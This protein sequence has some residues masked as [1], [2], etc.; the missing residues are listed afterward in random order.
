MP[1]RNRIIDITGM[2]FGRWT[3]VWPI[4][5]HRGEVFYLAFCSC[6][7]A[8]VVRGFSLRAG[9]S[10]SCGC[11]HREL[12]SERKIH[13]HSGETGKRSSEYQTWAGIIQRCLNPKNENYPHYGGR[14]IKVCRRWRKF[15]NFLTDMGKRPRG[16]EIDRRDN[17]G[18]YERKNCRWTTHAENCKNRRP[19]RRQQVPHPA[20]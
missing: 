19:R 18:N 5:L 14:G 7:M 13:G 15:N 4:G 10:Q 12:T 6:G 11:L 3:V 9:V 1:R 2:T 20:R 16:T 17:D 8:K